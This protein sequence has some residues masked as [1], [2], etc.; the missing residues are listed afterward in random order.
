MTSAEIIPN[1]PQ[2]CYQSEAALY[3]LSVVFFVSVGIVSTSI[4]VSNGAIILQFLSKKFDCCHGCGDFIEVVTKNTPTEPENAAM[5]L[6]AMT[7][8]TMTTLGTVMTGVITYVS[9]GWI[10]NL[11]QQWT[12]KNADCE[13]YLSQ[14]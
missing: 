1:K 8:K 11:W 3:A 5:L 14:Q 2:A 6:K 10:Y 13:F 7:A 9:A 12:A 4:L